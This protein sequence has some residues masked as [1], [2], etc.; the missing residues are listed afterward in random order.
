MSK[1]VYISGSITG[2][3]EWE[4]QFRLAEIKL[5]E[6]GYT[7]LSPI[8]FPYGMT[9][10]QYMTLSMAYLCVADCVFVLKGYEKSEGARVEIAYAK[11]CGM[12]IIYE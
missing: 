8:Y 10:K 7:V 5:C 11:K 9:Q 12:E 4:K 2:N 6:K 1:I 3:I